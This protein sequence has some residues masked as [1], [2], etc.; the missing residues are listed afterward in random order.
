MNED[1]YINQI[2]HL[3]AVIDELE[4]KDS[5]NNIYNIMNETIDESF[6][7][8]DLDLKINFVSNSIKKIL[9]YS[10]D[11]LVGTKVTDYLTPSS[12][13][14]LNEKLKEELSYIKKNPTSNPDHFIRAV[15][16]FKHKNKPM[17]V[18][19][20]VK[21]RYLL[22]DKM[23]PVSVLGT[24]KDITEQKLI[25]ETL[26]KNMNQ[27]NEQK[28]LKEIEELKKELKETKDKL[29]NAYLEIEKLRTAK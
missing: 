29:K 21:I 7:V 23:E 13:E 20:E 15:L 3:R 9:G 27:A 25:E 24:T 10:F 28:L 22:N 19:C 6:W 14:E 16:Q 12:I 11:E 8:A 18:W 26:Y 2:N 1:Y 5:R 17:N 4:K